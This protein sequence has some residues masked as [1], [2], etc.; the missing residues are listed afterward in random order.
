MSIQPIDK[1]TGAWSRTKILTA[2][3]VGEEETFSLFQLKRGNREQPGVPDN[4][5]IKIAPRAN[6]AYREHNYVILFLTLIYQ[7]FL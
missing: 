3:G 6:T 5:E 1:L 2:V 7:L 4:F